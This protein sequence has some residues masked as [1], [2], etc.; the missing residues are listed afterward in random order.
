MAGLKENKERIRQ[1][2]EEQCRVGMNSKDKGRR[3]RR[4]KGRKV[5]L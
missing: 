2:R 5:R 4:E 1:T 3:Q